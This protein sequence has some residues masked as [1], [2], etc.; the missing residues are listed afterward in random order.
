MTARCLLLAACLSPACLADEVLEL[1]DLSDEALAERLSGADVPVSLGPGPDEGTRALVAEFRPPGKWPGINLKLERPQDWLSH[2]YLSLLVFSESERPV[3]LAFGICDGAGRCYKPVRALPP[4]QWHEVRFLVTRMSE[5][6]DDGAYCGEA[7]DVTR[8]SRVNPFAMTPNEVYRV[9][10]ARIALVRMDRLP[11]PTVTASPAGDGVALSWS[12]VPGAVA[13]DIYRRRSGEASVRLARFPAPRF[14][15]VSAEPGTRYIYRVAGVDFGR[16]VGRRSRPVRGSRNAGAA[17]ALPPVSRFGGRADIS[18][19]A[20]GF[21]RTDKINGR[22]SLIDPDGRPFFS[23]GICVLGLGD[24]FTRVTGREQLFGAAIADREDARFAEAWR[25][26]YGYAAY[27]L[28]D[29]GLVFSPYIRNQIAK[30][31][32]DWRSRWIAR[33][34]QRLRDWHVNT[35]GAWAH[36]SVIEAARM[37]YVG[38]GASW[39]ECPTVPGVSAPDVFHPA[40]AA[41]VRESAKRAAEDRDDPYLIGRFTANEMAWHGDWQHG[42]SLVSL[43]HLAPRTLHAKVAWV[44]FLKRRHETIGE[45]NTA[46]GTD[47]G[48]FE[49]LLDGSDKVPDRP[50]A[51]RDA[52]DFLGVFAERYFRITS[53]ALRANDPNHLVL[54]ARHSQSAP[55]PVL[56]ANDRY[57]DVISVTLYGWLPGREVTRGGMY[58]DKPWLAGEFHFISE[59]SPLPIRAVNA[60]LPNQALRGEAYQDYL[61]EGLALPNFVGAHWFEYVDEPATGRF[62][63]GKDGGEAHN[64]GWVDVDDNPYEEF[65]RKAALVNANWPLS[66]W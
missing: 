47:A 28:R 50:A 27:G 37:P 66:V 11:A 3:S 33:T 26:W 19:R 34:V 56:E 32:E 54:G 18:L 39:G 64:I 38:F 45:L 61:A 58:T 43:I 55:V 63:F 59:D 16:R 25:P 53:E 46:W 15:D 52:E 51:R 7:V 60:V 44:E 21:F 9:R 40:F 22:W 62:N 31:G 29:D 17:P 5:G 12:R 23:I 49:A 42:K 4:R 20:T 2:T 13:Y 6:D 57:A 14:V 30:H 24:S 48:S 65:V 1:W 10:F 8:I 36:T 41:N 35:L